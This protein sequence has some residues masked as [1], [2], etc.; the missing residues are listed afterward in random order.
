LLAEQHTKKG[1]NMPDKDAYVQKLHAKLDGW[2]AEI[3][4]LKA[5]ADKAEAE[6]R[7]E[8]QKEIENLQE[9]RRE[10]EEK[11]TELGQ[12]GDGVWEDLKSGVQSAW[13]SMEEAV[14]SARTR[15]K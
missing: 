9:R 8:Y 15:F 4:K 1:K 3:D 11:L 6:S 10:A 13:D 14:K 7:L 12:A 2:N 5:K